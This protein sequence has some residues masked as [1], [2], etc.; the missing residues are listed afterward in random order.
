MKEDNAVTHKEHA[1]IGDFVKFTHAEKGN[2]TA[3]VGEVLEVETL[4]AD[5]WLTMQ[6]FVGKMSFKLGKNELTKAEQPVGWKKFKTDPD[7]YM[8]DKK[9]NDESKEQKIVADTKTLKTR[10][11]EF[12]QENPNLAE[13]KL[14]LEASKKFSANQ[15]LVKLHVRS[16]LVRK[17]EKC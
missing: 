12:V 3:Y 4:G 15:E 10:V 14:I 11:Y 1:S 2:K 17:K 8:N 5:A 6:T 9:K 13:A 7:S 16:A